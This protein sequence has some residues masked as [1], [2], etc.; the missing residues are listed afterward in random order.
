MPFPVTLHLYDVTTEGA[1]KAI[2][3]GLRAIGTGA[4]HGAVEVRGVEWSYGYVDEGSGVFDC[5]PMKCDAHQYRESL[6]MGETTLSEAE[7]SSVLN[8]LIEAWPGVEYDLLRKNCCTFSDT[9]CQELGVGPVP[10]WVTN[11]AGAGATL[12]MDKLAGG[13]GVAMVG[14]VAL[15][16]L[17]LGGAT[18]GAAVAIPAAA[19]VAAA[20]AGE[21]DDRF[22]VD[23]MGAKAKDLFDKGGGL[24]TRGAEMVDGVATKYDISGKID[25]GAAV[26]TKN[27]AAV[28]AKLD[29]SGKADAAGKVATKAADSGVAAASALAAKGAGMLGGFMKK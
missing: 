10:K 29:L 2:N 24:I 25:A 18:V 27:A 9:L 26:A 16:G 3:K 6:P 28:D 8:R 7:I 21:V 5:E 19:V 4:F 17:M 22:K 15:G 13:G 12:R 23:G 1:I 11:L 14:G 20:K